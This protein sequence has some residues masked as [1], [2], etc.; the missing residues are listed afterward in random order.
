MRARDAVREKSVSGVRDGKDR[1]LVPMK[2]LF[3]K[4]LRRETLADRRLLFVWS[5]KEK[6]ALVYEVPK[7]IKGDF[8][9]QGESLVA[10]G[11]HWELLSG[12][13]R[14]GKEQQSLARFP[15]IPTYLGAWSNYYPKTRVA[16]D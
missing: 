10:D 2:V 4:G 14:E 1:L 7:R 13:I 8:S 9:V 16:K 6:A 15:Y 12:R 5:E 11:M 3:E